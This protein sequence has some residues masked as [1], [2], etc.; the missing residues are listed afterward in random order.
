MHKVLF[1]LIHKLFQVVFQLLPIIF[2]QKNLSLD[3]IQ[4]ILSYHKYKYII[5]FYIL[6]AGFKTCAGRPASLGY[7]KK[8]AN[9][10]ALWTVD[11]LK[12]DNCNTDGTIPEVRYPPMRDALN[13]SG[14]P[15]FYS[16][17][18]KFTNLLFLLVD[19]VAIFY[20]EQGT[21]EPA[22]WA[23]NVGN[24]WRT[25]DDIEDNWKSM[26]NNIDIVRL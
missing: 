10:Y 12:Y 20:P 3:F 19:C 23:A 16:M 25:T 22:L 18:G 14:R 13:A 1:R 8:D 4:V 24:S 21:D 15:I 5:S 9:T 7:E 11:Y 17:C 6:D 2:I 26:L